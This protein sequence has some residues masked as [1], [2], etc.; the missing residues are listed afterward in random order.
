MAPRKPTAK[1][2][3]NPNELILHYLRTQ[4]RPYSTTEI[5]SNLHNKVTKAKADKILKELADKKEVSAKTSGKSTV[6]WCLQVKTNPRYCLC[7]F[8]SLSQKLA[9]GH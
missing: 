5:S 8:Y 7:Y 4:N 1:Q 9:M 6:Y 3:D 2:E